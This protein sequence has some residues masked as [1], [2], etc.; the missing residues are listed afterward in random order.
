MIPVALSDSPVDLL[1]RAHLA[2]ARA[3]RHAKGGMDALVKQREE[4]LTQLAEIE[5][6][7]AA[8]D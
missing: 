5:S 4:V 2:C 6:R 8:L 7:I 1:V 3:Q